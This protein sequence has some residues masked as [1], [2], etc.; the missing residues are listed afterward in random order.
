MMLMLSRTGLG[1]CAHMNLHQSKS[2]EET[3]Q[4][5][6]IGALDGIAGRGGVPSPYPFR[7]TST[8]LSRSKDC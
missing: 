1:S 5:S 4:D 7:P 8:F 6:V 2:P 3:R